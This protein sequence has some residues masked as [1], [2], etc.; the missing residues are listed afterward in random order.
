MP[1]RLFLP[2]LLVLAVTQVVAS[3]CAEAIDLTAGVALLQPGHGEPSPQAGVR[4]AEG[5]RLAEGGE[6][7]AAVAAYRDALGDSGETGRLARFELARVLAKLHRYQEGLDTL[8]PL[9]AD[10]PSELSVRAWLL[11]A[12]LQTGAGNRDGALTGYARYIERSGPAAAYARVEWA[13][14]LKDDN[15]EAALSMLAPVADGTGPALARRQALRLAAQIEEAVGRPERALARYT[16]LLTVTT[17]S[18][19]R[20]AAL[21]GIGRTQAALGNADAAADAYHRLVSQYPATAEAERALDRLVE[22]GRPADPLTAGIVHYRRRNNQRAREL[23]NAYLQAA[24]SVGPGAATALYYLGGLAERRGDTRLALENYDEAYR[25]DPEG[26]LAPEALWAR[27]AVLTEVGRTE[28]ARGLYLLLAERF[29]ASQRAAAAAFQAGYLA[30]LAGRPQEARRVWAAA[31]AARDGETAARAAFWAGRAAAELGDQVAARLAYTE[32]ARRSPTGYYGLRAAAVLAGE[33]QAPAPRPGSAFNA[34]AADWTRAEG[35]LSGW[36]GSEDPL[37]W[38]ALTTSDDWRAGLELL[39]VGRETVGIDALELVVDAASGQP[40]VLYRIARAMDAAGQPYLA[41][42]AAAR[43]LAR[44]PAGAALQP[45]ATDIVRLA[46]PV[47]WPDL[48]RT[49]AAQHNVD[50]LLVYA[51]MRQES[52]FN[53]LAGSPAGAFGLTQVIP[54]TAQEIARALG[55]TGFTFAD[56]ARPILAIQFGSYYLGSQLRSF[57]DVYH[58]LAAYNAG[59]GNAARWATAVPPGD[60]DR[61]FEA[62]DYSETSLYLRLVL[63]NY[64][65]YRYLYG[66]AARPTLTASGQ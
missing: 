18:S 29:P 40:W 45:E 43:L 51:M 10:P 1:P 50:P 24:G 33:P 62:V 63:Q 28:E 25:A 57:A 53:P 47:P 66:G 4:V 21:D 46:Y 34:P 55:R 30:Y 41:L 16:T 8:A 54:S 13:R 36:A 58:A 35:W 20:I 3:A 7:E 59:P 37:A 42:I 56:L 9:L 65:W 12:V 17:W 2:L 39:A 44:A 19:D 15:P 32:A 11:Y 22:L 38:Q 26:A 61:F 14:L 31:M 60:V 48:V 49:F 5:R 27:A 52:A 64:A 6:W 23:L